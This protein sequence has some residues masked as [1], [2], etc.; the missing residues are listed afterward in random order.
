MPLFFSPS[1]SFSFPFWR[2]YV[3]NT[4]NVL[5]NGIF[6]IS[7]RRNIVFIPLGTTVFACGDIVSGVFDHLQVFWSVSGVWSNT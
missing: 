3:Y 7:Y 1:S 6:E 4:E 5:I 2:K